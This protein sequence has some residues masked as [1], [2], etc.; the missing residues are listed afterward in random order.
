MLLRGRA[1]L[2]ATRL[3]GPGP[4]PARDTTLDESERDLY[5]EVS[6]R[7]T[8]K[9]RPEKIPIG[10]DFLMRQTADYLLEFNLGNT[11]VVLNTPVLLTP[12]IV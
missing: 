9:G 2:S 3:E 4:G 8:E 1:H 11:L 6:T 7:T 5:P 10:L 12:K